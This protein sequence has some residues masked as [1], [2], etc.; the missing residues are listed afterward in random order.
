M[1]IEKNGNQFI[2]TTSFLPAIVS[3]GSY[4]SFHVISTTARTAGTA[5]GL[6]VNLFSRDVVLKL[7]IC[8][9]LE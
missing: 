3:H 6:K 8:R 1:F 2:L 4:G 5:G 9:A 7:S